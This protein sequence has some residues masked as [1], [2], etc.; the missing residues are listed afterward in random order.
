MSAIVLTLKNPR[1]QRAL[2]CIR[3]TIIRFASTSTASTNRSEGSIG[4]AFTS[5]SKSQIELPQRFAD[6]K[7]GIIDT[8]GDAILDGWSRLLNHLE[9]E[10]IPK[11]K[12]LSS[13]SIPEVSFSS[14]AENGGHLPTEAQNLLRECG[15]IIIR[16]I[17]PEE[18]A[19]RWKQS[20]QDYVAA[21]PCTTGFPAGK[22]QVYELYWSKGQ[23]E[24]RSHTN[25][26]LAQ[27][28]LNRVWERKPEDRVVLSEPIAYCD[29][30]RMRSVS[31]N[32][33]P[34]RKFCIEVKF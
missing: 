13:N 10:A 6:L 12:E 11:V 15:T 5:L 1:I 23:L 26:L 7:R 21:N 25:M 3:R 22:I 4:D 2:P 27:T 33:F 19:L 34:S 31:H 24:A 14:I 28:A 29:R 16:G 18:Q 32:I 17:V 20:V 9:T 30:L 8:N